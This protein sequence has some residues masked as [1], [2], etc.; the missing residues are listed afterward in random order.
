MVI[1]LDC[2][3]CAKRY[4]VDAA[5]AGK[6]SRCKQCGE[7]F[8]IPVPYAKVASPPPSAVAPVPER[9]ATDVGTGARSVPTNLSPDPRGVGTPASPSYYP[10]PAATTKIVMNCPG[11]RKRYEVDGALAGK[12]SRCKDCGE[13]FVIPVPR[14][15]QSDPIPAERPVSAPIVA[16][17]P[18]SRAP[19]SDPTPQSYWESVDEEAPTVFKPRRSPASPAYDEVD[20]APPPRA[21]YAKPAR[22]TRRTRDWG[23]NPDVGITIAGLYVAAMIL[24]VI[25][26]WTWMKAASPPAARISQIFVITCFL[27]HGTGLL[28]SFGG[29]V[30]LLVIAFKE[31]MEQGLLCLLVP[32]YAF[33]YIFS[34]WEDTKGAFVLELLPVGNIILFF[35]IAYAVGIASGRNPA[36]VAPERQAARSAAVAAEDSSPPPVFAPRVGISPRGGRQRNPGFDSPA[37][38]RS[39]VNE[40]GDRAVILTFSG[41]PTNSEPANGVTTRDVSEAIRARMRELAPGATNFMWVRRNNRSVLALS[42]VDDIPGLAQRIDFGKATVRGDQ[43]DVV[44]SPEYVASVPRLATETPVTAAN[45]GMT[46]RSAEPEI[47][48]DADEV[49][50]SLAQLKSPD[51]HVRKQGA[52]RLGRI[53]PDDRL[54]EV[55]GALVTQL[56]HDDQWLVS[57]AIKALAVWKSAESV[58]PLIQRTSDNRFLIRHEAIK[59]LA[60]IKDARGVEPI[61]A[62]IKEDG[63]QVEDALKEMGQVAEPALIERL[64]YPDSGIRRRAC[65]ILKEIGGRETLR[66]MHSLPADADLGVRMAAQDAMR[67][68]VARVGPLPASERK[69]KAT[70]STSRGRGTG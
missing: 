38:V 43:I 67:N 8:K 14:G 36:D 54:T 53:A 25:G 59:T 55:V 20:L 44:L 42:P 64:T 65:V 31:K 17:I 11:C 45:V 63:F 66:A 15:R 61:L 19:A 40:H 33:Y 29:N 50:R 51:I 48:A 57:D 6:R 41:I 22:T 21:T 5:L 9:F 39:F 2:P 23:N 69:G 46:G 16:P 7:V 18:T 60:K 1:V 12:K 30:W 37:K 24:V 62:R 27:V 58:P 34:R 49:T 68:I 32:C 35:G 52:E 70:G 4:E 26:F 47:P 56:Q 13:V 28:L 3:S 10:S